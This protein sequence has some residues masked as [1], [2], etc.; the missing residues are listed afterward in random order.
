MNCIWSRQR[1]LRN[2]W[3]CSIN[4]HSTLFKGTVSGCST[5]RVQT[6]I[7]IE[8]P[9]LVPTLGNLSN[10]G[11][12]SARLTQARK[13]I[14]SLPTAPGLVP[15][16]VL[17]L[18]LSSWSYAKPNL[19]WRC[20]GTRL[21]W[22]TKSPAAEVSWRVSFSIV[23]PNSDFY[24]SLHLTRR[25]VSPVIPWIPLLL[26]L[27]WAVHWG[28][29]APVVWSSTCQVKLLWEEYCLSV[30]LLVRSTREQ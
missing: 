10:V 18:R 25:R 11:T 19:N 9:N 7:Q 23:V 5:K 28:Y 29:P 12:L 3:S 26:I 4:T 16:G 24:Y 20:V 30:V 21:T 6:K 27:V 2:G 1:R 14:Q 15:P 13:Q 17:A 8:W 22:R